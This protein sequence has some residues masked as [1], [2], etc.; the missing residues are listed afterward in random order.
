MA[1]PFVFLYFLL[2]V[3]VSVTSVASDQSG[4]HEVYVVYMGGKGSSTPGTLRDDQARLLEPFSQRNGVVQVYKHGFTGFAAHMS[5]EEANLIAQE[6]G[7]VSVSRDKMFKLRTTRSWS[8]LKL[9]K[10]QQYLDN[11]IMS[12]TELHS[13]KVRGADTIIGMMDSGI[14][15]ESKSFNDKGLGPIPKRWK[16][17][18]QETEDFRA[19]SCNRKI[20]GAQNY[21]IRNKT[22]RDVFGH[23]SHTASTAAGAPV[24]GVSYYGLALGTAIGGSPTS[25]IAAYKVCSDNCADSAILAGMDAAIHDGVD[26]MSL[27]LGP[28]SP[29]VNIWE[30]SVAIGAFHAVEHGIMVVCAAGNA[31]PSNSSVTNDVP[32]ITTVAASTIDR[33]FYA[34]VVLGNNHVIKGGGIQFSSL[35]DSPKYPL[36]D[37][38]SAKVQSHNISDKLAR[39]CQAGSLDTSKVKGRIV[40]CFSEISG[41][42]TFSVIMNQGARGLVLVN[43]DKRIE[44]NIILEGFLTFPFSIIS[45]KDGNAILSYIRSNR[46]PTATI[47]RSGTST[48]F[49]PAPVIADFSSRGPSCLSHNLLKPD[50]TAPGVNII[51]A[52]SKMNPE[53]ALPGQAPPDYVIISGTSMST[54][55]I[56]GIAALIKSQHPTW[57]H[58]A[59]RSAIMTTAVQTCI[60]GSPILRL[61]GLEEATPY[62]FGAGHVNIEQVMNPGLIYETPITEY[63]LFLCNYGY[64]ISTIKLIAKNI[65]EGFSCPKNANTALI[66]NMNYPSI[67]IA[68]FKRYTERKV[69]RTVTNVGDEDEAVYE[70]TVD[71]PEHLNVQVIPETLHFTQKYQKL[72]FDVIFSTKYTFKSDIFGW[73]TW[74]NGNYRVRSPFALSL[75][76]RS[77]K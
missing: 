10:F 16:G 40:L 34:S 60:D 25:R 62:D 14:W 27:S 29:I 66:S 26:I 23:G 77:S 63:Y 72:S 70:V 18:C 45:S 36:I 50:I 71:A 4:E 75:T 11:P 42:P 57:D 73:I 6:P 1:R 64:N 37:G 49:K 44:D 17:T 54:P 74:S 56:T 31:G 28:D 8:F 12:S 41:S 76:D 65:P 3:L 51:A 30:D 48:G 46:N 32:W 2:L 43:D 33:H 52:W 7:V 9:L 13:S 47:R 69:T 55:H 21:E 39:N 24:P 58:S 20:I 15:P 22:C 5:K 68:K 67:A 35:S 61:P 38:V 19:S 59:I 53:F